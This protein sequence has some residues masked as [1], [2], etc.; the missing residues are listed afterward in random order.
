MQ[1]ITF[2]SIGMALHPRNGARSLV[3]ER[4]EFVLHYQPSSIFILYAE[5]LPVG[6]LESVFAANIDA[7]F[8]SRVIELIP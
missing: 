7:D 2:F 4:H 8:K 6:E 5:P 1:R 3:L